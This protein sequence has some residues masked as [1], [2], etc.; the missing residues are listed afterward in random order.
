M[1][2][3]KAQSSAII[4]AAGTHWGAAPPPPFKRV[5]QAYRLAQLGLFTRSE[6]LMGSALDALRERADAEDW[7]PRAEAIAA[8]AAREA[9]QLETADEL[10]RRASEGLF[11]AG[12]KDFAAVLLALQVE[13]A[14]ATAHLEGAS[15]L[16][17]QNAQR[18]GGSIDSDLANAVLQLAFGA[19][20]EAHQ[21]AAIAQ[22]KLP[23]LGQSWAAIL[24]AE[25]LLDLE[26]P[27]EAL[28]LLIETVSAWEAA[29]AFAE[30]YLRAL[31]LIARARLEE[32]WSALNVG[33]LSLD[34]ARDAFKKAQVYCAHSPRYRPWLLALK[35]QLQL[36]DGDLS[37]Q[38]TF[39]E[40]LAVCDATGATLDQAR[41]IA[42]HAAFLQSR[43]QKPIR[44]LI[45]RGRDIF[46]R[47]GADER[48]KALAQLEG[49]KGEGASLMMSRSIM[50]STLT[51][52]PVDADVE[53][54]AIF[55]MTR[56][57][58][59]TLDL[60]QL[61]QTILDRTVTLL[62][63]E[64]GALLRVEPDGSLLCVAGRGLSPESVNAGGQEQISFGAVEQAREAGSAVLAD[65]A[66]V[67]GRFRGRASVVATGVRSIICA[68]LKTK[69]GIVG[70]IYLDST[71]KTRVFQEQ[72]KELLNVFATQA[73]IALENATAF[74]QID[75]LN[76][77]L[78]R[79]VEER[80]QE[81]AQANTRL[82]QSLEELQTTR[83]QLLEA[84]KERLEA[85]MI[86]ARDIQHAIVP[87]KMLIERPSLRVAGEV[88]SASKVGGDLWLC[89]PLEEKTLLLIGDVTGHG[90]GAGMVTTIAKAC[91]STV[92]HQGT[93]VDLQELLGT[94][95]DVILETTRGNL[96]MTAFACI[97]DPSAKTLT[98]ANAGHKP[99]MYLTRAGGMVRVENLTS[100]GPILGEENAK[101][102]QSQVRQY[103]PGDRV[104][105][106][107][108]GLVECTNPEG[109]QLGYR[110]FVDLLVNTAKLD[111]VQTIDHVLS[112]ATA[113]WAEMPPDDD[114]TLTVA[115]LL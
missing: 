49:S 35:Q 31:V 65:N 86:L 33:G 69:Q 10:L 14:C 102:F 48:S 71:V 16:I 93:G 38:R 59:S 68:P 41:L 96:V 37:S 112:S 15:R 28:P 12:E 47:S 27:K 30:P 52:A 54:N 25:A 11:T 88:R 78:E 113:F 20:N 85:E 21:L 17:E 34:A 103:S 43:S 51:A 76:R 101:H 32:Q 89:I 57:L 90:V 6:Q 81:L 29:S 111:P 56:A 92:V 46:S 62:K 19:L 61:L 80:T 74:S 42:R 82:Q 2:V 98:F 60:K 40:A 58:S 8:L 115:D 108:D 53:L 91:T 66:Q 107:T 87:P 106:F 95:S 67:D 44:L 24:R 5:M 7:R 22:A 63:A 50:R 75:E 110:A 79:R 97:V 3:L 109:L 4:R 84:E 99:P 77:T 70:F 45:A 26:R 39:D 114:V 94:L 55:E 83:L 23:M 36:L 13:A 73:S 1:N 72:H 100:S 18:I 105:L 64:R 104:V 9:A